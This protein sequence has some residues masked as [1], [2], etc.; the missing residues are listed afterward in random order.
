MDKKKQSRNPALDVIRLF[1]FIC[2]VSVHFFLNSIYYEL[3][4][5]GSEMYIATLMR[6]FFRFVCRYF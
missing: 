4:V 5:S 2:V 6:T 1:A 3:P